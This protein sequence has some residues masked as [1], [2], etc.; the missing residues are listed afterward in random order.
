MTDKPNPQDI[1]LEPFYVPERA[2]AIVAH[3]DDIEFGLS[4]T[5]AR[6]VAA[7]THVSYCIVSDNSS[8][9]NDPN[10]D[11]EELIETRRKEQIA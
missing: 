1:H 4:G 3:A 5:V 11:L 2:L 10:M 9:S 8:G 7:G 6:M